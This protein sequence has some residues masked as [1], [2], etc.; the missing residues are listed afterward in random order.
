MYERLSPRKRYVRFLGDLAVWHA[1]TGNLAEA[2]ACA[3]LVLSASTPRTFEF[4][5]LCPWSAAQV[6]RA[7]GETAAASEQLA[8]AHDLVA[9]LAEALPA[10]E[11]ARFEEI[12]WNREILAAYRR[13]EWPE[14]GVRR[15]G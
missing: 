14:L 15:A 1:R 13:N 6:L 8:R 5:Q 2:R 3:D 10:D 9:T 11:R 7:C 4:P 12:A